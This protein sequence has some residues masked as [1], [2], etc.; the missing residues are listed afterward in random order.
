MTRISLLLRAAI[1]TAAALAALGPQAGTA[2]A[3]RYVSK[4]GGD[5]ANN[6]TSETL[7]C[8]TIQNAVTWATPG[9]TIHIGPGTYQESVWVPKKL[10][11]DGN[12]SGTLRGIQA[13]GRTIVSSP[14]PDAPAIRLTGSGEIRDLRAEAKQGGDP[15][16]PPAAIE[17]GSGPP[18]T[19]SEATI[20]G[21]IAVGGMDDAGV[22]GPAIRAGGSEGLVLTLRDSGLAHAAGVAAL[23]LVDLFSTRATITNVTTDP[24]PTGALVRAIGLGAEADITQL[25]QV[26]GA[27]AGAGL[28]ADSGGRMA[29]AH[30]RVTSHG[31]AIRIL[32][33]GIY[34]PSTVTATDSA[35]ASIGNG[36]DLTAA[37]VEGNQQALAQ[38]TLR[39]STLLAYGSD[40]ASA[41]SLES[42]GAGG[43]ASAVAED[44]VIRATDPSLPDDADVRAV[45]EAGGTAAFSATRTAF[46]DTKLT[47]AASATAP[48]DAGNVAG[49]PLLVDES[50]ADLTLRPGSPAIDRGSDAGLAVGA[51][52]LAGAARS[53]DGNGDCTPA[54]DLGAY[55][56][57]AVTP[58]TPPTADPPPTG[59]PPT[60]GAADTRPPLLANLRLST[61]RVRRATTLRWTLDEAATVRILVQRR[62]SGRWVTRR[63]ISVSSKAGGSRLRIPRRTR[64]GRLTLG[65]YRL[66][67][68]ARDAAGNR[69]SPILKRFRVVRL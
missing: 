55:E 20:D 36:T 5:L 59:T 15:G 41:V 27:I 67:V 40:V 25:D 24:S 65:R 16:L 19:V 26:A 48:N 69:S 39:R 56:R 57:P 32:A 11:L 12:R 49:D 1:A 31:P 9:E 46:S 35:F 53:S 8:Y 14:D 47:G 34:T 6:C 22:A 54:P 64:T 45:G 13:P 38:L 63:V 10:I 4:G 66:R 17:L 68:V 42:S 51:L 52:D 60:G 21:V 50:A 37:A 30:S 28:V 44:S 43:Q 23:P 2:L 58:C 7:P 33:Q 62:A 29:V 18:G 61:A 3:D